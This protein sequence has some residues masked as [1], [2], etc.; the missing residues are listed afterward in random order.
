MLS[1]QAAAG[2]FDRGGT[3]IHWVLAFE[4]CWLLEL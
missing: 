3:G 4:K 1:S 2:K